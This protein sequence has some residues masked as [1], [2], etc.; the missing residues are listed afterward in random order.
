MD[1]VGGLVLLGGCWWHQ[2]AH[3]WALEQCDDVCADILLPGR[4]ATP[5]QGYNGELTSGRG[6]CAGSRGWG[7]GRWPQAV[8]RRW[9]L[10]QRRDG[11]PV[12]SICFKRFGLDLKTQRERE[13][14]P[15]DYFQE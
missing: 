6:G 8:R 3:G 7:T 1:S 13:I 12:A 5:G 2:K 14:Y 4:A 11:G 9:G 15:L 10:R